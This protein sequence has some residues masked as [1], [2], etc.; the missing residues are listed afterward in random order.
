[1]TLGQREAFANRH[2]QL[3]ADRTE[4][5]LFAAEWK[6]EFSREKRDLDNLRDE[7]TRL[8]MKP[9]NR[10]AKLEKTDCRVGERGLSY[11]TRHSM[12]C[13]NHFF[14]GFNRLASPW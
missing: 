13:A 14:R 9:E 2:S 10:T 4:F 5:A 11:G 7:F 1:L 6:E 12:P 8:P 3:A